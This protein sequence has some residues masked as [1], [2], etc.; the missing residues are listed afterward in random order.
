MVIFLICQGKV[1][2]VGVAFGYGEPWM[3]GR[4]NGQE[5]WRGDRRV[6]D[7]ERKNKGFMMEDWMDR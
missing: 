2:A 1:K 7:G 4:M 3:D 5:E 6:G